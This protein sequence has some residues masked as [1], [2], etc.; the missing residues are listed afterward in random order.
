MQN[1]FKHLERRQ[2]EFHHNWQHQHDAMLGMLKSILEKVDSKEE[3]AKSKRPRQEGTPRGSP[4]R[5]E[6]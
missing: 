2:D 6:P 3:G 1:G 4:E 5:Q